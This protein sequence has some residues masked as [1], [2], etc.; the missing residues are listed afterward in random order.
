MMILDQMRKTGKDGLNVVVLLRTENSEII[1]E[2]RENSISIVR[3][4]NYPNLHYLRV[5]MTSDLLGFEISHM[6]HTDFTIPDSEYG[7]EWDYGWPKVIWKNG[8]QVGINK[9]FSKTYAMD[10]R[11]MHGLG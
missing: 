11:N 1:L 9:R 10:L 7:L 6:I 2:L 4:D 5:N 3:R 8:I